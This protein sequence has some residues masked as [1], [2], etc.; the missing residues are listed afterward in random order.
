MLRVEVDDR[1]ADPAREPGRAEGAEGRAV[2]D[3]AVL[4][5]VPP[6]EMRDLVHVG[7]RAGRDRGEA[8]GCERGEDGRGTAVLALVGEEAQ[9]R[10]VHRLEHGRCQAVD[11]DEDDGLRAA[12]TG[13]QSRASV[14]SPAC[15]SG[16]R[17]R[18]R[19][20]TTGTATASR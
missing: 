13:H 18:S 6:D 19:T 12:R 7:K 17:L 4:V 2:L 14:R 8:Y 16:V 10:R 3:E 15:V 9:R 1:V 5:A 11:D 20:P